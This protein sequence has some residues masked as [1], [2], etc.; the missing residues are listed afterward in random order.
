MESFNPMRGIILDL[1]IN[2]DESLTIETILEKD[3]NIQ[4]LRNG[5]DGASA[6]L[7]QLLET[8]RDK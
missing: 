3:N 4:K 1:I 2:N 6:K 8:G 5:V 7:S